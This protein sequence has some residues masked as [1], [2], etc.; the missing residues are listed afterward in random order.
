LFIVAMVLGV[1]LS[2]AFAQELP[3]AE[4]R[5]RSAERGAERPPAVRALPPVDGEMARPPE[6][7]VVPSSP[8]FARPTPSG[9][10]ARLPERPIDPRAPLVSVQ[11]VMAEVVPEAGAK[12]GPEPQ[13]QASSELARGLPTLPLDLSAPSEKIIEELRKL[14]MRGRLDVFYR[15][16]LTTA[17]Q[18]SASFHF[19]QSQPQIVGIS[20]TTFG[21]TNNLQYTNTG[22]RV[23]IQ[24]RVAGGIVA[25][26]VNLQDSRLGRGEEGVPISVPAKGET[27]RSAPIHE[28]TLQTTVNVPNGQTI[29]LSGLISED[30]PRKR[31]LMVLLCPRIIPL[32]PGEAGRPAR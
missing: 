16:Q 22:L 3:R 2:A 31:Q 24:P 7:Y 27:I 4:T 15:I 20:L 14:G 13:T 11:L 10:R 29:V 28:F 19:G 1:G 21:Q 18:Q 12:A 30:G 9:D 17:D 25:M 6:I 26:K 23:E 5:S 8:A 32:N